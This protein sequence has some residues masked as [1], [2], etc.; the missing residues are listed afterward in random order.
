V[1]N[2]HVLSGMFTR[3]CVKEKSQCSTKCALDHAPPPLVRLTLSSSTLMVWPGIHVAELAS[4]PSDVVALA[5]LK[6]KE[7]EGLS[8]R[9]RAS[10]T[11]SVGE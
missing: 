11:A 10:A 7:L 6:A 8:E 1:N 5:E 2:S 4:F 3:S 9:G